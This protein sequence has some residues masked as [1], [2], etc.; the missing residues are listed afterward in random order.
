MKNPKALPIK[1]PQ[2]KNARYTEEYNKIRDIIKQS[3][4]EN[5]AS[6]EATLDPTKDSISK[7]TGWGSVE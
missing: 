3:F 1:L 7:L 6:I 4:D 5:H 2:K